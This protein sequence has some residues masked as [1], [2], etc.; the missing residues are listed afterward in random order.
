MHLKTFAPHALVVLMAAAVG[1]AL[2][3]SHQTPDRGMVYA[4][5][6]GVDA[7][8]IDS[9]T[10]VT[11]DSIDVQW[12]KGGDDIKHYSLYSVKD[13]GKG[14]KLQKINLPEP[15]ASGQQVTEPSITTTLTGL[16]PETRYWFAIMGAIAPSER[17]PK[18]WVVWS[19]WGR[20]TTAA[21]ATP[22]PT[23]TPTPTATPTPTPT[24]TPT[25]TPT[26][27]PTD[28]PTPTPTPIVFGMDIEVPS[29]I[30]EGHVSTIVVELKN[31]LAS[32]TYMVQVIIRN[33]SGTDV[34]STCSPNTP[35]GYGTL[36][37]PPHNE[38]E[39]MKVD[40]DGSCP[41]GDYRIKV[42]AMGTDFSGGG[43]DDDSFTIIAA[44]PTPTPDATDTPTATPTAT[45]TPAPTATATPTPTSTPTATPT[46][47]PTPTNTPTPT[48]TP[49][50]LP[51]PSSMSVRITSTTASA[52]SAAWDAVPG[53]TTYE[54]DATLYQVEWN[55]AR[56]RYDRTGRTADRSGSGSGRTASW[57][58]ATHL[59]WD[60]YDV[61]FGVVA[62]NSSGIIIG[63]GSVSQA[64]R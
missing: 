39:E 3:L 20:G 43:S 21:E 36:F 56:R 38:S 30:N 55:S 48:A 31:L 61:W 50:P 5:H 10:N 64:S 41:S 44:T 49:T 13:N 28:T 16:K 33:S 34:T 6:G 46:A 4:A 45:A 22:T 24:L 26:P 12:R 9:F 2:F 59:N 37:S 60:G 47:T 17:A 25:P 62:K 32:R 18:H 63:S 53:A 1:L 58:L 35:A 42:N 15:G 40:I 11:H 29:P 8:T 54:W 7:P 52:S 51:P 57:I 14:V 27:T 19:N 23:S